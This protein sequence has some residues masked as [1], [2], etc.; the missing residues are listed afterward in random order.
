MVE[1]EISQS[2]NVGDGRRVITD[3]VV[4]KLHCGSCVQDDRVLSI[5]RMPAQRRVG[6]IVEQ[7][8]HPFV[9]KIACNSAGDFDPGGRVGV[10]AIE[11]S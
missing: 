10:R 5:P 7:N 1:V 9:S 4:A 2:I 11:N 3:R 6:I 8:F